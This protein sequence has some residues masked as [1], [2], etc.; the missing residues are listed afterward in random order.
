MMS[1]CEVERGSR[2]FLH[3]GDVVSLY[4]EGSESAS[5][6]L[7]TLGLV[8][9]RCLVR[10][11]AGTPDRPPHKFRDCHFRVC[12]V[13]RYAA[14]KQYWTETK[15]FLMGLESQLD[16][17]MLNKLRVAA[18]KE[19]EQ[20]DQEYRKVLGNIVQYG[21]TVQLLH[22][23]S[24]KYLTVSKREP[25]KV[26][27]NAMKV[28]LDRAGNDGSWF[29]IEPVY[30]HCSIGDN[31]V[32]GDKVFFIPYNV[33]QALSGHKHQLHVSSLSLSDNADAKEVNC[34]NE[35]TCW[36]VL[37][38]LHHNEILPNVL[39]SGDV[40]RLFHA[41][42]QK[43]LTL[44]SMQVKEHVFLRTTARAAAADA[45]SSK[46]LW[47]VEVNREE[48]YRGGRGSWQDTFRFKHLAT[49]LYL[50]VD[51][52]PQ[53][54]F[55]LITTPLSERQ[56]VRGESMASVFSSVSSAGGSPSPPISSTT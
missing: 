36:Q 24:D 11:G 14:Q 43:F 9:D 18:E 4:A 47:E 1:A 32:A 33:S 13:N 16:D 35:Q 10:P 52:I 19:K 37:L 54:D 31:V 27:R 56:M 42:Q 22:V 51:E 15:Q 46:A 45:T 21:T 5:G 41:D 30:R 17:D 26:E 3:I 55:P 8:D 7:S 39:K 28:T 40:V 23:K 49:D 29:V 12:S 2:T 50:A 34:L 44:D 48:P 6:F 25:A 38:F 53:N 20:N